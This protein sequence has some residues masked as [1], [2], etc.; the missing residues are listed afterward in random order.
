[1]QKDRYPKNKKLTM[2]L[3]WEISGLSRDGKDYKQ[4]SCVLMLVE[5]LGTVYVRSVT[6]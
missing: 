2:S 5:Q 4:D 3:G 6:C 1:M